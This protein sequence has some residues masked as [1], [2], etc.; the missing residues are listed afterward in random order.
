MTPGQI[1]GI[2]VGGTAVAGLGTAAAVLAAKDPQFYAD[3]RDKDDDALDDGES[4]KPTVYEKMI[5]PI[6]LPT[7]ITKKV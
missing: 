6:F 2:V 4:Y 7:K 3:Y 5:S 1:A